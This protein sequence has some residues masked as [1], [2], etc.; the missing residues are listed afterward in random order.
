MRVHG[1][2][3]GGAGLGLSVCRKIVENHG[4]SIQIA[5]RP[6]GGAICTFTLPA[7]R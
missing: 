5:P 2:Q 3:Y 6:E 1:R 7:E 4:G